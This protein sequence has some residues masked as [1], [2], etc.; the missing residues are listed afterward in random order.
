MTI[1]KIFPL[2]ML[3]NSVCWRTISWRDKMQKSNNLAILQIVLGRIK[4]RINYFF[5]ILRIFLDFSPIE[6]P[7]ILEPNFF[8]CVSLIPMSEYKP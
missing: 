7:D 8:S 6:S 1:L 3:L 5:K 4:V 2:C